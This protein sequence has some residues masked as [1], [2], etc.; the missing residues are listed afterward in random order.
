MFRKLALLIVLTLVFSAV[1]SHA[2]ADKSWEP[3]KQRLVSDGFSREYIDTVFAVSSVKYDP[4]IMAR[5]MRALLKL[6]F[7]PPAEKKVRESGYDKRYVGPIMLAG[8]YSYL[9]D[10]YELL[11][12]IDRDYGV[13]PSVV[14]ALLLVETKLGYTLGDNPAFSNL[15][16][17]AASPNPMLFLTGSVMRSSK[18]RTWTGCTSALKARPIGRIVNSQPCLLF[19]PPIQ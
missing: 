15:A 6:H 13:A 5:K 2:D 14:V 16:N 19:H 9:R 1:C 12:E 4:E 8:A 7:E 3:L 11:T 17:M 10:Q 18:K